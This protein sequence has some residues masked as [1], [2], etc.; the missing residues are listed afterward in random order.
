MFAVTLL[1]KLW[2]LGFPFAHC[3]MLWLALFVSMLLYIVYFSPNKLTCNFGIGNESKNDSI[4]CSI[5][6]GI[7]LI[8][9]FSRDL[10]FETINNDGVC[11]SKRHWMW[12]KE[13]EKSSKKK[14]KIEKLRDM[15]C[16]V[17]FTVCCTYV[18]TI[19]WALM[20]AWQVFVCRILYR[21]LSIFMSNLPF[22][23]AMAMHFSIRFVGKSIKC[24]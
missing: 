22:Q 6:M 13:N 8:Y 17:S 12:Q 24:I 9:V 20:S 19:I 18:V 23:M 3:T 2:Q 16:C 14:K 4:K 7:A 5:L 1:L 15:W 11:A 21:G 10:P